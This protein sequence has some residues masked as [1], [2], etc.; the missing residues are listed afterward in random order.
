[1][2]ES[3]IPEGTSIICTN[4]TGGVPMQIMQQRSLAYT[5]HDAKNKPLLNIDDRKLSGAFSCVVPGIFW[6]GLQALCLGI[7]VAALAL[8]TVATGGIALAVICAVGLTACAV[9]IGAGVTALCQIAHACDA[10]LSSQWDFFHN[11]VMIEGKNALLNKSHLLCSKGGVLNLI[12]DPVTASVAAMKI[13][14]HNMNQFYAQMGS[15]FAMGLIGGIFSGG[16]IGFVV[17]SGLALPGYFWGEEDKDDDTEKN[18]IWDNAKG[19]V[20]DDILLEI[21]ETILTVGVENPQLLKGAGN[22]AAGVI[23]YGA[24]AATNN[25]GTM[26]EG[27]LRADIGRHILKNRVDW[28]MMKSGLKEGLVAFIANMIIGVGSD[29]YENIQEDIAIDVS[30]AANRDDAKVG[31]A[32]SVVAVEA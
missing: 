4:M 25:L 5:L 10:T 26:G 29:I 30:R 9:G 17:S 24:G 20:K 19:N 2:A 21:P 6:G 1:M 14:D 16:G 7:A 15:Q 28:Q 32:I 11:D 8:A 31:N 22:Y 18:N 12:I 23:Q 27:A 13:S 3:Y